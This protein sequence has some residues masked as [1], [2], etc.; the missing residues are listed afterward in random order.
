MKTTTGR[1]GLNL[2]IWAGAALLAASAVLHFQLWDSE[3]YRHIP[4][5]GPLFLAQ[6]IVGVVLST[7]TA[8]FHRLI[9]VA[10]SAGLAISSIGGLLVAIWFGL[11]G[12]QE[13]ASAPY[14]GMAFTIEAISAVL[15]G[16]ATVLMAWSW[17]SRMRTAPVMQPRRAQPLPP[18][19]LFIASSEPTRSVHPAAGSKTVGGSSRRTR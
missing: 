13:T 3:G 9:L 2:L 14:V 8:I 1:L 12:W 17:L 15:L 6:A 10:A 16:G 4:T 7:A 11:F 5:I 18:T 19:T